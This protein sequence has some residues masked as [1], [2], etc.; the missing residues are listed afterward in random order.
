WLNTLV[1]TIKEFDDPSSGS[2]DKVN[3]LCP[4]NIYYSILDFGQ[5][6]FSIAFQVSKSGWDISN[7]SCKARCNI[8]SSVSIRVT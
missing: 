7:D 8:A 4:D 5:V 6:L 1:V 3:L 2:L